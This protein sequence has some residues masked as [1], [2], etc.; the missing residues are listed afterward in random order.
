[1][2]TTPHFIRCDQQTLEPGAKV[3]NVVGHHRGY[4]PSE[5]PMTSF[6]ISVVPP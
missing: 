3:V 5:R 2:D 1:M 4:R 6:M